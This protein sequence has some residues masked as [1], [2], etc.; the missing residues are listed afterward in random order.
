MM[1]SHQHRDSHY[2]DKTVSLIFVMGSTIPVLVTWSLYWN[3]ALV[4]FFVEMEQIR[5]AIELDRRR[6]LHRDTEEE[7]SA[8]SSPL[9]KNILP[10]TP[11][12]SKYYGTM[13]KQ[14]CNT[15]PPDILKE[16]NGY[17]IYKIGCVFMLI[18]WS[19]AIF[20][21]AWWD[22][23]QN[24]AISKGN[25]CGIMLTDFILSLQIIKLVPLESS[26]NIMK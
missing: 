3:G 11:V 19:G 2:K 16:V 25:H 10:E 5:Q 6:R 24:C 13:R 8:P 23:I 21:N 20:Q 7:D 15:G 17:K 22:L 9:R 14:C 18:C 4:I 1:P 26:E 12:L